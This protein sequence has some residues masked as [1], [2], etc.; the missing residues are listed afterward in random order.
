MFIYFSPWKI[1]PRSGQE[2]PQI[3]NRIP[4][5]IPPPAAGFHSTALDSKR[6]K[7]VDFIGDCWDGWTL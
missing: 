3:E 4:L 7:V 2:Y 1:P 6:Y 5:N